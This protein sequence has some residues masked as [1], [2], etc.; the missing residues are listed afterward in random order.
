MSKKLALKWHDSQSNWSNSLSSLRNDTEFADVTLISEDKVK[1]SAHKVLLAS[2]SSMF[3][4]ILEGHN[5]SIPL[6]YFGGVSSEDLGF[7]LDYIYFGEIN[8]FQEQ[9]DSFLETAKKLDINGLMKS[10]ENETNNEKYMNQ[11]EPIKNYESEESQTLDDDAPVIPIKRQY[12][13]INDAT[14]IDVSYMTPHEIDEKKKELFISDGRRFSC[15]ECEYVTKE[16]GN[17]NKHIE[18]HLIHVAKIDVSSMT[19]EEFDEKRKELWHKFDGMFYC[20]ECDYVTK[21]KSNLKKHIKKHFV[22][23]LYS[24]NHCN[25]DFSLFGA[26]RYHKRIVHK[27]NL[28]I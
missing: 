10:I 6:L 11:K 19:S 27:K 15:T 14:K 5:N 22:G 23:L 1:F 8:I 26:L 18:K 17:M 9:L 3:K 4:F 25:L 21:D 16:R 7:I 28:G 2:C 12:K 13:K 24:C 20:T